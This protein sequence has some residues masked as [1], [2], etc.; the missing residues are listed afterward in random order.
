MLEKEFPP[1]EYPH[2]EYVEVEDQ[3]VTGNFEVKVNSKLLH[4]KKTKGDGFLHQNPENFATVVEAIK[5]EMS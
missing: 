4:S 1:K 2:I 3:G 5:T